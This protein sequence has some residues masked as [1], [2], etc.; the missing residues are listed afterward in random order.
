MES[1][2][3]LEL[4]EMERN[5]DFALCCGGGGGRFWTETKAEERF[6]NLRLEEAVG[7]GA[8]VL[9]TVCPF[10]VLNFEDTA[11]A[12]EEDDKLSVKDSRATPK[13]FVRYSML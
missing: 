13:N 7:T 1:I 12:M 3:G 9:V 8:E 2:P 4:V 10:C 11:K 5:R 6:S